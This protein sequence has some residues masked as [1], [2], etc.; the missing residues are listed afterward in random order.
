MRQLLGDTV[1]RGEE[2]KK[3]VNSLRTKSTV[4]KRQRAN[5]STRKV[6]FHL[7]NDL[8]LQKNMKARRFSFRMIITKEACP[9]SPWPCIIRDTKV[10]D[11]KWCSWHFH[12]FFTFV[13]FSLGWSW[14]TSENNS[15]YQHFGSHGRN[16]SG[17]SQEN[18]NRG[19]GRVGKR[20]R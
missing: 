2:L 1:L 9:T 3:Y 12:I 10:V 15:N 8:N 18:E 14:N 11:Q 7:H 16:G 6:S 17:Q 5:L 13:L 19:W 20:S 4:Y